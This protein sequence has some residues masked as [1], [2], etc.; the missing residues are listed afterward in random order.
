MKSYLCAST[1]VLNQSLWAIPFDL[2]VLGMPPAFILSQDQTLNKNRFIKNLVLFV[3]PKLL[4]IDF[5]LSFQRSF[6]HPFFRCALVIYQ[7]ENQM[8][9]KKITFFRFFVKKCHFCLFFPIFMAFTLIYMQ[10]KANNYFLF[11]I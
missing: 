8:S 6:T 3:F 5:L 9:T 1:P 10:K 7:N 4:K 11:A 2:H